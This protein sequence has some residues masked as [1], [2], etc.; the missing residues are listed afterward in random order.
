MKSMADAGTELFKVV[1]PVA[2][3]REVEM[4]RDH[5]MLRGNLILDKTDGITFDVSC[6][7][8]RDAL[9]LRLCYS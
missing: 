5:G 8:E 9:W 6:T 1:L 3:R 7:D 2:R 4:Y